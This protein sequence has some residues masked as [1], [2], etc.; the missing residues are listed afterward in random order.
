MTVTTASTGSTE[1][2]RAG[3]R[4]RADVAELLG[5]A[6]AE[7]YLQL[8]EYDERLQQAYRRHTTGE[9]RALLADLPVDRLR[10]HQRRAT[11]LAAARTSV[12][13]HGAAY[14]AMVVVV[15]TVWLVVGLTVDTWYFWPV[16]PILG[17]GIGLASHALPI[18]L[19]C[20][21]IRTLE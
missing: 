12:R 2:T 1:S 4:D 21:G 10:R 6:L 11:Q 18:H 8:T 19:A 13:I 17:A 9:L 7:G 3:D 20:R 16:W 14:L 15:L 5:R